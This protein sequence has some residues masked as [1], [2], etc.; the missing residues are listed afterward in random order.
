MLQWPL[1]ATGV[2]GNLC[3]FNI[4]FKSEKK[5]CMFFSLIA[6]NNVN[7]IR[8]R[9]LSKAVDQWA[10]GPGEFIFVF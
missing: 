4:E 9:P 6:P 8:G 10:G 1:R 3:H 7:E 2:L 5:K